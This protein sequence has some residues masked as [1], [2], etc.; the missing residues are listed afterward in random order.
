[1]YFIC[2]SYG[3]EELYDA[4]TTAN[5]PITSLQILYK[6]MNNGVYDNGMITDNKPTVTITGKFP[7]NTVG[8]CRYSKFR[9]NEVLVWYP[10]KSVKGFGH[11]GQKYILSYD[12][13]IKTLIDED[14]TQQRITKVKKILKNIDRNMSK[15]F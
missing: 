14:K 4:V 8:Y 12:G 11:R 9:G 6:V 15:M 3:W 1:M 2:G 7:S 10:L 5:D 13:R